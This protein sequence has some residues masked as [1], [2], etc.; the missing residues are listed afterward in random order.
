MELTKG[1]RYKLRIMGAPIDVLTLVFYDNTSVVTSTSVPNL[2]LE[3][4]HLGI[5]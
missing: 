3:N 1:L 5:C 2:T 4:N